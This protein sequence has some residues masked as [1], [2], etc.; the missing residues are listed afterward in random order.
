MIV[1]HRGITGQRAMVFPSYNVASR[2]VEFLRSHTSLG[3]NETRI[4]ELTSNVQSD[5]ASVNTQILTGVCAVIFPDSHFQTA[6]SFW[7]HTGD[8]VSSRRAEFV[9]RAYEE[10]AVV[11]GTSAAGTKSENSWPCKG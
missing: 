7:Q 5:N 6:K 3:S 4:V 10:G 11:I 1:A 9:C 2:C 8:G